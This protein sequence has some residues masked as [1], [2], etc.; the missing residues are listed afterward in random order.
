[1]KNL[2][3]VIFVLFMSLTLCSLSNNNTKKVLIGSP[4]HQKP[5]ILKEFLDSL[6]ELKTTNLIVD[7]FFVDDNESIE[8]REILNDFQKEFSHRC[9]IHQN[10][11]DIEN[12]KCDEITHYWP[13]RTVWKVA[14]FKNLMIEY[15]KNRNYDFLFLIDS[16]IVLHSNTLLH[17]I[18]T[19]KDIISEVF[20]TSWSPDQPLLPQVWLYDFYTQYEV[21]PDRKLT[22]QEMVNRHNKFIAQMKIPGVYEVGGLCACTLINNRALSAP[23]SFK[24]IKNLTYWG[25]DRHF[26]IRAAALGLSL[27]VDTHYPAYHIYRESHLPG[28]EE[29]KNRN[30]FIN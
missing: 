23:I 5:K 10:K 18:S 3:N 4:V 24:K 21:L 29:Y 26:C 19:N 20:W 6:K 12:Y 7:F 9:I 28:V 15:A 16:D 14:G 17:L 11:A 25:E 1:M 27:F 30:K 8:S 22:E 2:K 13:D